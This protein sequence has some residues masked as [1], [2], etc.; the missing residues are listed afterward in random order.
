MSNV[1]AIPALSDNYIWAIAPAAA[2]SGN[3]VTIVDP[4]EAAPVQA[5][6]R[7]QQARI[8]A[9]IITHHHPDHTAGIGALLEQEQAA[10]GEPVPV[11][12][13][14]ADQG[15]V[16]QIT[17]P[18]AD[19][20]HFTLDWLGLTFSAIEVPGHTL[21]HIALHAPGLLLAGD[22][23]FRG[24]CGRVF[25]GTAAQMQQSL[26]RLR[27]LDDDTRVYAGHEYTQ[28]NL[29]FARMVEPDNPDIA[30]VA[31]EVD[32]IRAEGKPS[33]PG[34]IGEERRINPFLRWDNPQVA[35]AASKRAGRELTE[36]A[37]IFAATRAW[38]D[39]S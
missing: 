8:G 32:T 39:A 38:K 29:A 24:G 26:A 7:Q 18:L 9:I 34:T 19:G 35:R 20:D 2:Q 31:A 28:K 37:D 17:Q 5:W 11:Y 3:R 16:A 6:L 4:G 15:R 12:G 14:Q 33:L 36:A 27:G 25:E 21:G 1:T 10:G 22:T 30:R 13:P 23:L